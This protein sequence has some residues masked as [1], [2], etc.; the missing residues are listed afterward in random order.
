M[1]TE[2]FADLTSCYYTEAQTIQELWKV[3][4]QCNQVV[5][6]ATSERAFTPQQELNIG[7]RAFKELVIKVKD[8]TKMQN[9][10]GYF[11][12][13]VNNLMDEPYFDYELLDTF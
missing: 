12:G 1:G 7:I 6:Y 5:N 13:I 8:N 2:R 10:F 3:V 9:K 11:N 4:K